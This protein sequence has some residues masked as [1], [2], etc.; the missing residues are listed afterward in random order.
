MLPTTMPL[1]DSAESMGAFVWGKTASLARGGK[2]SRRIPEGAGGAA[3]EPAR[4]DVPASARV[5]PRG[6]LVLA[7]GCQGA[8]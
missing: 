8:A 3:V 2:D 1:G 4:G 5:L 6:T 7:D